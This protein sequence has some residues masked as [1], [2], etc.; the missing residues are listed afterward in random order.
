M[1]DE[2]NLMNEMITWFAPREKDAEKVIHYKNDE[3]WSETIQSFTYRCKKGKFG[4]GI[5]FDLDE[6]AL[7]QEL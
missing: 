5:F 2:F 7:F 4:W 3:A 6:V 1:I